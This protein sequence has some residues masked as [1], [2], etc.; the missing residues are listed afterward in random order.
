[1]LAIKGG[2]AITDFDAVK[3]LLVSWQQSS[4]GEIFECERVLV[5][6]RAVVCLRARFVRYFTIH[7]PIPISISHPLFAPSP[8]P[9]VPYHRT[10]SR[11]NNQ[12]TKNHQHPAPVTMDVEVDPE[13]LSKKDL[14]AELKARNVKA[15]A[16]TKAELVARLT[17]A[18]E[19]VSLTERPRNAFC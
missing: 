19:K 2:W 6:E 13:T 10:T 12:S 1:M 7:L 16:N 14:I 17:D 18:I 5:S 9:Y 8:S 11:P 4:V 3:D 15:Y